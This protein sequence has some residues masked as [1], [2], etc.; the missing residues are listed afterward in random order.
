[1]NRSPP[2]LQQ[3]CVR[4]IVETQ[5]LLNVLYPYE[6]WDTE[7]VPRNDRLTQD[8]QWHFQ[9]LAATG[10]LCM[11]ECKTAL[12][13]M[14]YRRPCDLDLI[15]LRK[16]PLL[17]GLSDLSLRQIWADTIILECQVSSNA[18]SDGTKWS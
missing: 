7:E 5:D 17:N 3:I 18:A 8:E 13:S 2:S 12:R 16:L 11:T 6:D 10:Q 14:L 1:M 9:H 15:Q 4:S